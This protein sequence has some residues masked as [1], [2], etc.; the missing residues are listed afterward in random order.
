M[1]SA[2]ARIGHVVEKTERIG[3]PLLSPIDTA[4]PGCSMADVTYPHYL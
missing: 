4:H 2:A 1:R 3:E